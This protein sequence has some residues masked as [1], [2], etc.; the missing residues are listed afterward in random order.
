MCQEFENKAKE[1]VRRQALSDVPCYYSRREASEEEGGEEPNEKE[2]TVAAEPEEEEES[3]EMP[4]LGHQGMLII[5]NVIDMLHDHHQVAHE[6]MDKQDEWNRNMYKTLA[7]TTSI[8]VL[9]QDMLW[10][11]IASLEGSMGDLLAHPS[12][13]ER[14]KGAAPPS[15]MN[16]MLAWEELPT[17]PSPYP[18]L[19][20]NGGQD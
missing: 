8:L 16:E 3:I 13:Q 10:E 18:P 14:H 9:R 5:L 7:I 12:I 6:R 1:L 4:P 15:V 2:E 11:S 17:I 20:E 19:Q